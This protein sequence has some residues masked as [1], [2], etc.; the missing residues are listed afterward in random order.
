[1][2]Y[3]VQVDITYSQREEIEASSVDEARKIAKE[4]T[5][6]KDNAWH[7][8]TDVVEVEKADD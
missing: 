4:K 3:N 8:A 2:K 1:M 5:K 6:I 7:V